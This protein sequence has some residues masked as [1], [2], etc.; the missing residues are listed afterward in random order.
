MTAVWAH[1]NF[2][3]MSVCSHGSQISAWGVTPQDVIYYGF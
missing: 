1:M 2:L 3:C